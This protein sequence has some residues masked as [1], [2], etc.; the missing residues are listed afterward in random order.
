MNRTLRSSGREISTA[1][2]SW[3][4]FVN[5][6]RKYSWHPYRLLLSTR[7]TGSEL[8]GEAAIFETGN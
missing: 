5:M 7:A 8:V 1:T 6:H 2:E 4:W 3:I